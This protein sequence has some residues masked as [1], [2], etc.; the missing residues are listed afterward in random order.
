LKTLVRTLLYNCTSDAT[1][2]STFTDSLDVPALASVTYHVT[3]QIAANVS[4]ALTNSV[5]VAPPA[6]LPDLNASNDSATD[7]DTLAG[8]TLSI[9]KTAAPDP[10]F[11]GDVL[12]YT[13]NVS[14]TGAAN[15]TTLTVTDTLPAGATYTSASGSGWSC[16]AAAGV[17]TCTR[18][19]LA[20]GA[21]PAIVITVTAPNVTTVLI[22]SVTVAAGNAPTAT[23]NAQTQVYMIVPTLSEWGLAVLGV[24]LAG[25]AVAL[26]ACRV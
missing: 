25:I 21:A 16:G 12:T 18:P 23:A 14:N 17:V 22:N 8:T 1:N 19:L 13:V 6:G 26:L 5:Q 15:A 7:I 9:A 10:V 20:P 24:L 3:A 2:P 11:A 4:G